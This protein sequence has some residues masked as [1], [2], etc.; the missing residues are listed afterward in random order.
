MERVLADAPAV[1]MKL[2]VTTKQVHTWYVRRHNS[3]FPQ[4]V[5]MKA[6]DAGYRGTTPR[7]RLLWD[8]DEVLAWHAQYVPKRGGAGYHRRNQHSGVTS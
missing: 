8:M 7:A 3:G 1:A 5:E 6:H 4:F 2:G